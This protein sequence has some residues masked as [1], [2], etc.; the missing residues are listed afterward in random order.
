MAASRLVRIPSF[1][2]VATA[3]IVLETIADNRHPSQADVMVLRLWAGSRKLGRPLE[4]IAQEIIRT[5]FPK[6]RRDR[7]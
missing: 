2:D 7:V 5:E 6:S 3:K 1:N 4:D